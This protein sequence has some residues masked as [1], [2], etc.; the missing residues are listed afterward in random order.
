MKKSAGHGTKQRGVAAAGDVRVR[1]A[2]F[3]CRF[4]QLNVRTAFP[5]SGGFDERTTL[6]CLH[7]ES[8]S[9]RM[10]ARLLPEMAHERSL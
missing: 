1:R 4:G 2:Y 7:I 5:G 8:G 10:F 6:L 9:S 3:E